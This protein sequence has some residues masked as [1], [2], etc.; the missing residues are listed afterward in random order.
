LKSTY[1]IIIVTHNMQQALRIAD[2]TAVM[3]VG[4]LIEYNKT[5]FIFD[6]PQHEL[7]K[8]YVSGVFS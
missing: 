8:K 3:Y 2:Y 4:E 7:T 1:T 5:S 6:Q